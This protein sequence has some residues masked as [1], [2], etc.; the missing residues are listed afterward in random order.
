[1]QRRSIRTFLDFGTISKLCY[2]WYHHN[3]QFDK[4][5]HCC[6]NWIS[7]VKMVPL[8]KLPEDEK[9]EWKKK[10]WD[11]ES[12]RVAW[13]LC[14]IGAS[15]QASECW[16]D[17]MKFKFDRTSFP[18]LS[19]FKHKIFGKQVFLHPSQNEKS[20]PETHPQ[21]SAFISRIDF[22]IRS[23]A[24]EMYSNWIDSSVF[25]FLRKWYFDSLNSD[26][27]NYTSF[28]VFSPLCYVLLVL[29][30]GFFK[31]L[32]S[33]NSGRNSGENLF[34]LSLKLKKTWSFES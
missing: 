11:L 5:H 17:N 13:S 19:D 24:E 23:A 7:C 27:I 29:D 33:S 16:A 15:F 14:Q 26:R 22:S 18:T 12:R 1:M 28:Q 31:P 34:F 2:N 21:S 32:F 6:Q 20:V 25:L 3:R 9:P 8:Q 10:K 4:F 30:C